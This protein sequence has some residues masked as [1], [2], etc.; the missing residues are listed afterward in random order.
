MCACVASTKIVR[1]DKAVIKDYQDVYF[2]AA[3][4]CNISLMIEKLLASDNAF[5]FVTDIDQ[6][7]LI[8]DTYY[9]SANDLAFLT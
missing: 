3:L 8:G 4:N 7:V 5:G 1:N 6:H 2:I 9:N